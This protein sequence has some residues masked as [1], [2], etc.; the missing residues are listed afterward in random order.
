MEIIWSEENQQ[1]I[2]I[3][4]GDTAT[5]KQ[6]HDHYC[7]NLIIKT[8]EYYADG[9]LIFEKDGDHIPSLY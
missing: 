5:H 1:Y 4:D 9:Q 8:T 3:P 7:N 6:I 2:T